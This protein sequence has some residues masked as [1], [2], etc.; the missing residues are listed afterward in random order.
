MN[1]LYVQYDSVVGTD[2]ERVGPFTG[3]EAKYVMEESR[4]FRFGYRR[5]MYDG[6]RLVRWEEWGNEG[7]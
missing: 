5:T 2:T 7:N 1:T 4:F 6:D 3:D